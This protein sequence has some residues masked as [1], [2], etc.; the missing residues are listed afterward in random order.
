MSRGPVTRIKNVSLMISYRH[1]VTNSTLSCEATAVAEAIRAVM[2]VSDSGQPDHYRPDIN[3]N[4]RYR[5]YCYDAAV[6]DF[7]RVY[8]S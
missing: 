8:Q 6:I 3:H 4:A 1:G 2:L 5:C 7:K